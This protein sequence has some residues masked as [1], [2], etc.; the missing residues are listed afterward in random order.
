MKKS[1]GRSWRLSIGSI[2]Y[3]LVF[4]LLLPAFLFVWANSLEHIRLPAVPDTPLVGGLVALAGIIILIAGIWSIL[5]N[6]D[7]LPMNA[8]P[9]KRYVSSG[10]YYWISHPIY[11]GFCVVC[12]GASI[13]FDSGGGLWVVTPVITLS[14]A[15][16]VWGYERPQL[17]KKFGEIYFDHKIRLPLA[18]NDAPT[19]MDFV[20][21]M[22][23]V[24]LPWLL[25]Y[26][27]VASYIGVVD[28]VWHSTLAFEVNFPVYELFAVP[29]VLTYPVVFLAPLFARSKLCQR[30][31]CISVILALT[32]VIPFYL[33]FPIIAEFRPLEPTTI[34][35]DLIILQHS[36]DNPATAFPA[37]HVVWAFLAAEMLT[38]RFEKLKAV[39]WGSAWLIAISCWL[40]GMHAVLDVFA[41]AFVYLIVSNYEGIWNWAKSQIENLGNSW[42][43]HKIGPFRVINHYK[44]TLLAGFLCI[45]LT[46]SILGANYLVAILFICVLGLIF[47]ALWAQFI[48]GSDN[49]KRPFGYYGS[50]I[51][52]IIGAVI[53][54]YW[55]GLDW[56]VSISAL[57]IVA[58]MVQA[59]GRLRCLVH[60][61]CHG[62]PS[63]KIIGIRVTVPQPR[64]CS[65]AN[66][67]GI[68]VHPTQVYSIVGNFFIA[69]VMFRLLA[70]GSQASNVVSVYLILSSLARFVEEA[71]RG[72]PQTPVLGGLSIYQWLSV[73]GLFAGC[74]FTMVPSA[75]VSFS[76]IS[77]NP[78]VWGTALV[79]GIFVAFIMSVDLPKSNK[80]FA[81][82]T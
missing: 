61:C 67:N 15:A 23:L 24:Y 81:R 41:G 25:V 48:E 1:S 2:S 82:L 7:G 16:L 55:L 76:G 20:S 4:V 5:K 45:F 13:W 53:T 64:V 66:L 54:D 52:A 38:V 12:A 73:I 78:V 80:R 17:I 69:M 63:N 75:N 62:A 3:G 49:L 42:Y 21:I 33:T 30:K 36:V 28:P 39:N 8:Y 43:G 77:N 19:I 46:V 10:I 60:G 71:Y 18:S 14:S 26:Q 27:G 40:T 50:V 72:E 51:G 35:G 68:P 58:P 34:W 47:S 57:C 32:L 74:V 65:L 22:A 31:F 11:F 37:F 56:L 9:P 70:V 44:F 6:G 79:F 29:Y 59:I